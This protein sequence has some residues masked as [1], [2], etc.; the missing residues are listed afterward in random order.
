MIDSFSFS[1][2]T[3]SGS[4]SGAP[5]EHQEGEA[6][7]ALMFPSIEG[8]NIRPF[9]FCRKTFSETALQ[10]A[11]G[12]P[13]NICCCLSNRLQSFLVALCCSFIPLLMKVVKT[14]KSIKHDSAST[15]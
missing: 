9:H 14:R 6:G 11:G 4:H 7:F 3:P 15:H 1:T 10:E 8:V 5:E 2:V 12:Q 13:R